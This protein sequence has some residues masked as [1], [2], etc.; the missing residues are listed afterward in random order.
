MTIDFKLPR[1][2][3]NVIQEAFE[4]SRLSGVID[5]F[6]YT[7]YMISVRAG[8]KTLYLY[9]LSDGQDHG[10]VSVYNDEKKFIKALYG[11]GWRF[12]L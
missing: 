6:E 11:L 7:E 3:D 8:K 12:E 2:S 5:F 4:I 10:I 1:I 9:P